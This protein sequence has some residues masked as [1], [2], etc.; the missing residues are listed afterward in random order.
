LLR[1]GS[2]ARVFVTILHK[3][4][5][6]AMTDKYPLDSGLVNEEYS[7][8]YGVDLTNFRDLEES[9]RDGRFQI[10]YTAVLK[11]A[12]QLAGIPWHTSHEL[13]E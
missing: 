1:R 10:L 6:S 9:L 3:A 2:L 12:K 5:M 4:A 11:R 7:D 13:L 8:V